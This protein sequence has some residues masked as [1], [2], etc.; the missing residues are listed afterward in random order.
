MDEYDKLYA[1]VWEIKDENVPVEKLNKIKLIILLGWYRRGGDEKIPKKKDQI[2]R[3]FATCSIGDIQPL[4]PPEDLPPLPLAQPASIALPSNDYIATSS[5]LNGDNDAATNGECDEEEV[6][7]I[8]LA[9]DIFQE[10]EVN[11]VA[12]KALTNI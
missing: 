6:A 10:H 8:L 7:W 9:A 5:A 2:A 11:T 1:K 3:Y 4:T 12:A